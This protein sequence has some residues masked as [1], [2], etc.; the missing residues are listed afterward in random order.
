MFLANSIH[1]YKKR[2]VNFFFN[3]NLDFVKTCSIGDVLTIY[4]FII[5]GRKKKTFTFTG[6]LLFKKKNSFGLENCIDS[7][8]IKI[9]F[10]YFSPSII[11]IFKSDKYNFRSNYYKLGLKEKLS[12][13]VPNVNFVSDFFNVN[14]DMPRLVLDN[15]FGLFKI[16]S[17]YKKKFKKV[18]KKFRY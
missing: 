13:T 6:I 3:D 17:F 4:Y 7:E 14:F 5:F 18:K 2:A 9:S 1:L 15:F 10:P 11:G 16:S 8:T 12:L